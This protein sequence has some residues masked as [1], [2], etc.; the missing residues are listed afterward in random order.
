MLLSPVDFGTRAGRDSNRVSMYSRLAVLIHIHTALWDFKDTPERLGAFLEDLRE[1]MR[2]HD[3]HRNLSICLLVW[4]LLKMDCGDEYAINPVRG[5]NETP[6][7]HASE[8]RSLSWLRPDFAHGHDHG[9][10][11]RLWFVSRVLRVAKLLGERSWNKVNRA[12]LCSLERCADATFGSHEA[13]EEAGNI[14]HAELNA[15]FGSAWRRQL[16]DEIVVA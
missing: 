3:V 11:T 8:R 7:L 12:L 6:I 2:V 9:N 1:Q 14:N 4:I 16:R 5:L 10:E 13:K 15:E